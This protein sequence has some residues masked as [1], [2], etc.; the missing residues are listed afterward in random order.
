MKRGVPRTIDPTERDWGHKT[1]T[2]RV[3]EAQ[4]LLLKE[5]ADDE[6]V[7]VGKLVRRNLFSPSNE[8]IGK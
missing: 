7:S 6:G 1:L 5:V 2:V 4:L 3:T 8:F